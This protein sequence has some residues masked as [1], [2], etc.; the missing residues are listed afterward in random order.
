MRLINALLLALSPSLVASRGWP[1]AWDHGIHDTASF[2]QRDSVLQSRQAA[3]FDWSAVTPS[4]RLEYHECYNGY[5]CARLKVPLDWST[6]NS[7]DCD[8]L[9]RFATIGIATLPAT[10]PET[11]PSFG[12]S[13]LINPGGPGGLGT[14]MVR[15]LGP[16]LQG[17]LEGE[18]HYEMIGFDPRG[19]GTSTPRA[20]CY[21]PPANRASDADA[22]YNMVSLD[23][24]VGLQYTYQ[25]RLALGELCGQLGPDSILNHM[26]TASVARDMLEIVDRLNELRRA[27][28]TS[29]DQAREPASTLQDTE[30]VIDFFYETCFKAGEACPLKLSSDGSASDIKGR[31][32]SFIEGLVEFP[33]P[34]VAENR[35]RL[36]TPVLMR[37]A[38]RGLTYQP[39]SSFEFLADL[40]AESLAGNYSLLLT[41]P[42]AT[43][44][45][46]DESCGKVDRDQPQPDSSCADETDIS[47]MC[48]DTAATNDDLDFA[49][50][51]NIRDRLT[52]QAPTVSEPWIRYTITCGGWKYKPPYSFAGPYGNQNLDTSRPEN[53][54]TAPPL[55][56]SS[57]YDVATPL[58]NAFALSELYPG[59]SVVVQESYGHLALGS[60][61]SACT[62][63]YVRTYFDTGKLPPTGSTCNDDCPAAIPAVECPG[64]P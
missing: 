18:R 15:T 35:I 51:R 45:L 60:S 42:E 48:A 28:S 10:V 32:N 8:T 19:V 31:V 44:H 24:D 58:R 39:I 53:V 26:S 3:T 50:A 9:S 2:H 34:I 59:S 49:A 14:R 57:R 5:K 7:S 46:F 47:V 4:C 29:A 33:V 52:S 16:Y 30:K 38:I 17:I 13:V 64:Y 54:P 11:D 55:I 63:N 43:A 37:N 41:S 22:R 23:N 21:G 40:L 61:P 20:D 12:G 27:N 56:L 62:S 6:A 25:D 36:I 1:G